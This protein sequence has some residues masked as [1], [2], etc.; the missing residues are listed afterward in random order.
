MLLSRA[1]EVWT[2][3]GVRFYGSKGLAGLEAS[4]LADLAL[5]GPRSAGAS[6]P[7][8]AAVRLP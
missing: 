4:L 8:L 2:P 6:V 5:A 7:W 3:G 1:V